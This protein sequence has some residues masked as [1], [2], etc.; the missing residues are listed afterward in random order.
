MQNGFVNEWGEART[1]FLKRQSSQETRLEE[2]RTKVV[3]LNEKLEL[4]E[5][6]VAELKKQPRQIS[7]PQLD[8]NVL[9]K[10]IMKKMESE[11]RLEKMR[12]GLL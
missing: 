5:K 6:L 3:K 1:E 2:T 12:R 7:A 4:Q 10:Q 8:M 9:T 11:L